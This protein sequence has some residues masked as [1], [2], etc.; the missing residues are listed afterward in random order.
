LKHFRTGIA[1]PAIIACLLWA[2]AFAGI[3]AGLSYTTPL[4]FAGIR[5][6]IAGLA[7][8]PF[9]G[10]IK[11]YIRSVKQ[12]WKIVV[13]IGLLQNFLQYAFF[14][15]GIARLPASLAAIINGSQPLFIAFVAHFMMPGDRLGLR[16]LIPYFLGLSGVMLVTLGRQNFSSSGEV[17]VTGIILLLFVNVIA[18]FSNI[19]V[20]RDKQGIPPLVLSSASLLLGGIVLTGV[21]VPLEGL[22]S[23][24]QPP[25]YYISLAWLSFLSAAAISIWFTL[26]KRPGVKVSELNFWKFL[27]PVAGALLSWA[28][29]PSEKI[30]IYAVSGMLVIVAALVMINFQVL[31]K[32]ETATPAS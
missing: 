13:L 21:S 24:D 5:F 11:S 10:G 27:I 1:F 12:H 6:I 25:V 31:K 19:F 3:K 7:I 29:I 32:R 8:I 30:N 28:L 26:L 4:N 23:P 15:Q 16:R 2:S 20:S 18:A 9:A 22:T 17:K 14:Y